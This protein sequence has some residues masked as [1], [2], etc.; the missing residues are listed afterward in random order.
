MRRF[1]RP[2]I[3]TSACV[4][5]K[6]I[7]Q[8]FWACRNQLDELTRV[9]LPRLLYLFLSIDGEEKS[10]KRNFRVVVYGNQKRKIKTRRSG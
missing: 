8:T 9:L 1:Q 5:E 6:Y 4:E 2:K 10:W 7:V 3:Y